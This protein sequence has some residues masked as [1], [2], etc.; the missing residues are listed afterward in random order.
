MKSGL[1]PETILVRR[2]FAIDIGQLAPK[3]IS[4][5]ASKTLMVLVPYVSEE[6]NI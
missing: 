2:D 5:A 3:Q 6:L 1:F 4:I